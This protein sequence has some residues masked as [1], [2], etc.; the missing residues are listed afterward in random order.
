MIVRVESSLSRAVVSKSSLPP[1]NSR[2][3]EDLSGSS[4]SGRGG[5]YIE[6][7]EELLVLFSL[8]PRI[9]RWL[10]AEL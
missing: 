7:S 4:F 5:S 9:P 1:P 6:I 2:L 8:V 10:T 3:S